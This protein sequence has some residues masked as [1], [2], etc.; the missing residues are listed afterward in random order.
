MKQYLIFLFC[1]S[2]TA[3]LVAQNE[4]RLPGAM[5]IGGTFSYSNL[6]QKVSNASNRDNSVSAFNLRPAIGYFIRPKT[7]IGL[8][9]SFVNSEKTGGDSRG[10]T[11][12]EI[13]NGW[14]VGPIMRNY[15]PITKHFGVFLETGFGLGGSE[16]VVSGTGFNSTTEFNQFNVGVSPGAYV[17]LGRMSFDLRLGGWQY[18]RSKSKPKDSST[19]AVTTNQS[20]F[21]LS[22]QNIQIGTTLFFGEKRGKNEMK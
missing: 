4:L 21:L 2:F 20:G 13:L 7:A 14:I 15:R 18:N 1:L 6:S 11:Q 3:S 17:L 10:G 5:F 16:T 19:Q 12:K 8:G 9:M 22:L